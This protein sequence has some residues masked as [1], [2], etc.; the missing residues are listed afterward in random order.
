MTQVKMSMNGRDPSFKTRTRR[1]RVRWTVCEKM[2]ERVEVVREPEDDPGIQTCKNPRSLGKT[3][4]QAKSLKFILINSNFWLSPVL[5]PIV[6]LGFPPVFSKNFSF[7]KK[8]FFEE[9]PPGLPRGKGDVGSR[10]SLLPGPNCNTPVKDLTYKD[11][12]TSTFTLASHERGI[13]TW[14]VPATYRECLL[15][16]NVS[17]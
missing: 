3:W 6:T 1:I 14:C 9:H 12:L 5:R 4:D 16:Q 8:V 13:K 11:L 7:F 17:V 10:E 2:T 15:W